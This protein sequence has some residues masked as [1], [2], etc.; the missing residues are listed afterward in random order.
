MQTSALAEATAQSSI[1]NDF[2]FG[3]GWE[4]GGQQDYFPGKTVTALSRSLEAL[5]QELLKILISLVRALK[6]I[7]HPTI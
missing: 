5:S 4:W 6:P 1:A 3:F 7:P 2:C